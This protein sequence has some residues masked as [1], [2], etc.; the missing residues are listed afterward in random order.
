MLDI[1]DLWERAMS[2][3]HSVTFAGAGAI[4]CLVC[5]KRSGKATDARRLPVTQ[6]SERT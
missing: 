6:A 1:F 4:L 3:K 2:K 5:R